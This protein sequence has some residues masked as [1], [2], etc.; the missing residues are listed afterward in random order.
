MNKSKDRTFRI[1]YLVPE[2]PGQTHIMFWREFQALAALGVEGKIISSRRPNRKLMSHSWSAEAARVTEYL[3]PLAAGMVA[4]ILGALL[5]AGPA[6]W[7]RC[8]HAVLTAKMPPADRLR[9][10]RL[11]PFAARLVA[12]ARRHDL[13]HIH[14]GSCGDVANVAMFARLLGGPPYSLS[15]LGPRLD[16]YGPNQEQKWKHAA[17]GLFQSQ[18]LRDEAKARIG[19]Y[20]PDKTAVAPVGVD[21]DIMKRDASYAPWPGKGPC[22]IYCCARLNPVKGHVYLI[23]AVQQLRERWGIDARL[24]LGGEDEAGGRSYRKVIETILRENTMEEVV[25][26]LGAVSEEENRAQY[27]TA[28]VYAMG[29]LDEATGAI[30][31]MEAMAMELPVVMTDVGATRELMEDGVDALLVPP[32]DADALAGAIRLILADPPLARRLGEAG[33]IKIAAKFSH[34]RSA[35]KIREFLDT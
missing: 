16:T 7:G 2:F 21:V 26:L 34:R 32:R 31:A 8:V 1:G 10:A 14:V 30:A 9:L 28:H 19:G 11:I 3:H 4:S 23:K 15:L 17:F 12:L 6:A 13:P 18:Q 33:R 35:E 25:T 5:K 27:A 20:L 22:R 29:S 24:M